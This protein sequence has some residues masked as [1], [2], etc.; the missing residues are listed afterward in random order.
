MKDILKDLP[1]LQNIN[2]YH[3]VTYG[4]YQ[5]YFLSFDLVATRPS[6]NHLRTR[7]C[8]WSYRPPCILSIYPQSESY[9]LTPPMVTRHK[10]KIGE[11]MIRNLPERTKNPWR[12]G[13][14][15]IQDVSPSTTCFAAP[16]IQPIGPPLPF[17]PLFFSQPLPFFSGSYFDF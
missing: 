6:E 10:R 17:S 16:K 14:N 12:G 2:V 15:D 1:E 7:S 3:I 4:Y 8:N 13:H 9:K 5:S 11:M